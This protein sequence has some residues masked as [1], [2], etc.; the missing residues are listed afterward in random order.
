MCESTV[1]ILENG[2]EVVFFEDLDSLETMI[3][4]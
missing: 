3:M 2:K 1:Y 4:K